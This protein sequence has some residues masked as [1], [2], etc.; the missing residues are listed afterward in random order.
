MCWWWWSCVAR[1]AAEIAALCPNMRGLFLPHDSLVSDN[2][3]ESLRQSCAELRWS[4]LGRQLSRVQLLGVLQSCRLSG[5]LD[6]RTVDTHL[7]DA[8]CI[9]IAT[10][11]P[12]EAIFTDSSRISVDALLRV[13]EMCPRAQCLLLG[14]QIDHGTFVRL[15]EVYSQ[16][17]MLDLTSVDCEGITDAG[18]SELIGFSD[19]CTGLRAICVQASGSNI[20]REGLDALRA[21]C[22][23]AHVVKVSADAIKF[24]L[25]T[26][27]IDAKAELDRQQDKLRESALHESARTVDSSAVTARDQARQV[28][29]DASDAL[30]KAMATDGPLA[31]AQALPPQAAWDTVRNVEQQLGLCAAEYKQ[32]VA[33]S[34]PQRSTA[35]LQKLQEND[36]RLRSKANLCLAKLTLA[37]QEAASSTP[38]RRPVLPTVL[39]TPEQHQTRS[40][41]LELPMQDWSEEHVQEWIGVIGLPADAAEIVRRG[42]AVDDCEGEDL[43]IMAAT[44]KDSGSVRPLQKLLKKAGASD[45]AA[46]AT[47]TMMLHEAAQGAAP[48]EGKLG[49][50][51]AA[52]DTARAELRQNTVALRSQV[53]Q[54]ASLA[55]QHFP[56]LLEHKDVEQ[57][58]GTDGLL[59]LDHRQ[60]SDYDNIRPIAQGRNE[61]LCAQYN[62]SVVCLKRFPIQ[63]DMRAYARELA[64]VRRLQH[65]FIIRYTAAFEDGGTM[66]LEMEYFPQGS[67]RQWLQQSIK[68]DAAK[69]RSLLRQVLLALVCMHSQNIVHC[70]IKAENVL[71]ADDGTPRICDFEMSKD[72]DAAVSS[73]MAGGTMRF[74]APEVFKGGKSSLA[75]DMY[76]FG[77]VALNT[78]C[79]P[80]P[81]ESYPLT[82]ASKVTDSG[83]KD[84]ISRLLD[85][86]PTSRPTAVQLQA[87]PYFTLDDA[88][89]DAA[90]QLQ[91]A[92]QAVARAQEQ[93]AQAQS[94]AERRLA[95]QAQQ[96]AT[97]IAAEAQVLKREA[98][99]RVVEARD[100]EQREAAQREADATLAGGVRWLC[101]GTPYSAENA[102]V[103]EQ[104]FQRMRLFPAERGHCGSVEVHHAHMR[105]GVHIVD[106]RVDGGSMVQYRPTASK[107]PRGKQRPVRREEA[108]L[109]PLRTTT[110]PLPPGCTQW[111]EIEA[112]VQESLPS[113][114]VTKLEQIDNNQLL[115]DF[116]RQKEIVAAKPTNAARGGTI[117]HRANVRLCFHGMRGGP[118][119]LKK[120]YEGGRQDGGFDYRLAR[121]E[122][123]AYGRGSYF[124]EHAIYSTYLFPRP[125]KAADGSVVL[126][127]AEVILGQSKDLGQLYYRDLQPWA[128][129]CTC[130]K[131]YAKKHHLDPTCKAH[132]C[133]L[134]REPQVE[135]GARGEVYDSIQG[136]EGSL[137]VLDQ[138]HPFRP[139][140]EQRPDWYRDARRYGRNPAG[141]EEYGRQ[142]IVYD[143]LKAYPRFLVT[144]RPCEHTH[145]DSAMGSP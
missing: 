120:I 15:K 115:M 63:G 130:R 96:A 71:V 141:E 93:A 126:L 104:A 28:F 116:D 16:T 83:L 33:R 48:A 100:E 102:R 77:M 89:A 140:L 117:D 43:S 21:T 123:S 27:A 132:V 38:R 29:V 110:T 119:E 57:F 81:G 133:N 32:V 10:L 85:C 122:V 4:V 35:E 68:P 55:S 36:E 111:A 82:D 114:V 139:A 75:S 8:G 50:A 107:R 105:H 24:E 3:L 112:R 129:P 37:Q 109:A 145:G 17:G 124:A 95:E 121:S 6:V 138:P 49:A 94:D 58:M 108:I 34:E 30:S 26:A 13:K 54:L 20:T 47:Q 65:P 143:K 113:H 66:Y 67:L 39:S 40:A 22:P 136:T 80:G 64:R 45:P 106:V 51:Q 118:S 90:R 9:Q 88:V 131:P 70:D 142:Y 73:T 99:A 79:E 53:V 52:L 74:M 127:V 62:G 61:V 87:E 101:E 103:L 31:A 86:D 69:K 41:L 91:D 92:Q 125:T 1:V 98:D 12:T 144:I 137:G 78:V 97:T 25:Q 76:A 128:G 23:A 59:A 60:L 42:L 11:C 7:T 46:L 2:G 14:Q 19:I 134:V 18:L 56:E 44:Y 5:H 72:L 135:G 84:V